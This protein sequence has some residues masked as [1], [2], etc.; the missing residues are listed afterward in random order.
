[1]T[2][3]TRIAALAVALLSAACGGDGGPRTLPLARGFT[4]SADVAPGTALGGAASGLQLWPAVEED[5]GQA[6]WIGAAIPRSAW[7]G[8]VGPGL[9]V[10]PRPVGNAAWLQRASAPIELRAGPLQYE[11]VPYSTELDPEESAVPG[12]FSPVLDEIFLCLAPG[13][14][15]PAEAT[16]RVLVGRGEEREGAWHLPLGRWSAEGLPVWPGFREELEVDAPADALLQFATAA[17]AVWAPVGEGP[18]AAEPAG[19]VRFRVLAGGEPLF[20]FEQEVTAGGAT[21]RHRV[22][23]PGAA[24]RR[25]LAFEVEGDPALTAFL[26]PVLGPAEVG[27]YGARPWE[28]ERPDLVLF[29]ADTFRADSLAAYG[30]EL[31]LTPELDALAARSRVFTRAWSPALWTLPSQASMMSGVYP[32]QHGATREQRSLPAEVLTLAER[33]RLAGYRTGAVTDAGLVSRRHGFEQ[34]FEWFDELFRLTFGETLAEC[35]AFLDADDGRPVFL[36]VQ[37]Y[38]THRPYRV[39]EATRREHGERLGIE[40]DWDGVFAELEAHGWTNGAPM[41]DAVRGTVR[42][43]EALYRGGV[44]DLDRGFGRFRDA[45]AARGI[46]DSGFLVFTSDHGEAFGEHGVLW[47]QGGVW[48]EQIRV[49]LLLHGPG[50]EPARVPLAA[51]LVDVAPT[52][53]GAAGLPADPLWEG[54]SLFELDVDRSTFSFECGPTDEHLM[55]LIGGP[56]KLIAP[57]DAGSLREGRVVGAYEL[58]ADPG[59]TR[60]VRGSPDDWSGALL[61]RLAP[62]GEELLRPLFEAREAEIGHHDEE[63][64]RAIGYMGG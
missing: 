46:L 44:V 23:L 63:L 16:Y 27:G 52:L 55:A 58:D 60:D 42:R 39:S 48:D 21:V 24:G 2:A 45:L 57:A 25:R 14:E 19:S 50:V 33:L 62:R 5:H 12:T 43:L 17:I 30:G 11:Y 35:E 53:A 61:E 47:H 22:R 56:R 6:V 64:M 3:L 34:G 37:T 9:W 49:P 32:P 38:R 10:A 7:V 26:T 54:V 59:E 29:L 20:A 8:P 1:M 13:E 4:P 31:G 15:P 40:G 41:D 36:F 51:T 18:G 28:E